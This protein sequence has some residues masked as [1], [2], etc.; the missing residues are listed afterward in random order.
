MV[1]KKDSYFFEQIKK[2]IFP[3]WDR[4]NEWRVKNLKI[5]KDDSK[6]SNSDYLVN[7]IL[8]EK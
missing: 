5:Y 6:H 7:L 4:K 1:K 8:P 2:D 3:E